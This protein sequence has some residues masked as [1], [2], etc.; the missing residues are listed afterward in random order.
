MFAEI[1]DQCPRIMLFYSPFLL[2][3]GGGAGCASV[4]SYLGQLKSS[5]TSKKNFAKMTPIGNCT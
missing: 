1:F 5:G 2:Y 4:P 3:V